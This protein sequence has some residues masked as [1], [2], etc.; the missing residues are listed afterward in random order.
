MGLGAMLAGATLGTG[1]AKADPVGEYATIAAPAV[2]QTLDQFPTIAGVSGVVQ[3]IMDDTG[4]TAY[5]AGLIIGASVYGLCPR[6]IGLIERFVAVYAGDG[7]QMV[8]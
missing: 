3:G 5:D 1:I 4:F 6:H 7:R 2:C 8:A